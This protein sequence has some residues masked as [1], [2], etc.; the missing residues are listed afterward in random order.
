MY[1]RGRERDGMFRY[2]TLLVEYLNLPPFLVANE[3]SSGKRQARVEER[4][5][6]VLREDRKDERHL[7]STRD[8]RGLDLSNRH[9]RNLSLFHDERR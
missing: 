9:L 4:L 5:E 3:A 8:G 2:F 6:P 7:A 1:V